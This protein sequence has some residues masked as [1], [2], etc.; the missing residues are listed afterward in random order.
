MSERDA[1]P[2]DALHAP[3]Q[4]PASDDTLDDVTDTPQTAAQ[5][6]ARDDE[7]E[8]GFDLDGEELTAVAPIGPTEIA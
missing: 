1:D 5:E 4:G 8:A 3:G 2:H 6:R 7:L